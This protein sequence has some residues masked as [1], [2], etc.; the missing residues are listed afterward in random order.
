MERAFVSDTLFSSRALLRGNIR[1]EAVERLLLA[2]NGTRAHAS[3]MFPLLMSV[4]A[5]FDG[6]ANAVFEGVSRFPF[7][8][9]IRDAESAI[10]SSSVQEKA[11][12]VISYR[13]HAHDP[14]IVAQTVRGPNYC[15]GCRV[16]PAK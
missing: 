6:T 7:R 16:R 3:E 10:P 12:I 8:G 13:A 2:G 4:S 15:D 9:G 14:G 5:L 1:R 11:P